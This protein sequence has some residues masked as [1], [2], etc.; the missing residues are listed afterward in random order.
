[1]TSLEDRT[2]RAQDVD[3]THRAG[4]RLSKACAEA[5]IDMRTLQPSVET[6][7]NRMGSPISR[8]V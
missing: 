4:A 3:I 5:G 7:V 2:V 1:M 8:P 6:E